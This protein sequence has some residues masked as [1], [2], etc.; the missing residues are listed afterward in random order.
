[1]PWAGLWGFAFVVKSVDPVFVY[2]GCPGVR[3][4]LHKLA[5]PEVG[6]P[7]A[8]RSLVNITVD[9]LRLSIYD[10]NATLV[11]VQYELAV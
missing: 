3:V 7:N 11:E 10:H 2:D 9:V 5:F 8:G 6:Y 1:M 4:D